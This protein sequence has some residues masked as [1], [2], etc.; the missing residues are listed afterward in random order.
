MERIRNSLV[1]DHIKFEMTIGYFRK[2][3]KETATS[4]RMKL[5]GGF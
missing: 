1:L 2:D 4:K 3:V 5:G